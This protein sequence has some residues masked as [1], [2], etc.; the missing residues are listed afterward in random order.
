LN[1]VIAVAKAKFIYKKNFP[2]FSSS[3]GDS[4]EGTKGKAKDRFE[5]LPWL[6]C[7]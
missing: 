4:V 2:F 3:T 7:S 1:P 6:L 5:E